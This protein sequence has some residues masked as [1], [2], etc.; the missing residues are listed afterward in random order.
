LIPIVIYGHQLRPQDI[1]D[2]ARV[3]ALWLH[4]EP[5]DGAR[6]VAAVRG[7]FAASHQ[8]TIEADPTL[9]QSS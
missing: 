5:A 9:P 4:I 1:E 2:A 6:L 7:L 8:D 3:G